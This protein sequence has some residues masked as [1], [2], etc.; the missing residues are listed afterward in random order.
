MASLESHAASLVASPGTFR[1]RLQTGRPEAAESLNAI[2]QALQ[3]LAND[4]NLDLVDL[5]KNHKRCLPKEAPEHE[6]MK[7]VLRDSNRKAQELREQLDEYAG[8]KLAGR[9][10]KTW[11]LRAGLSNSSVP[12][13][14]L[15]Q[16]FC[17][18][19]IEEEN[20]ISADYIGNVRN[21][22]CETLKHFN[23]LEGEDLGRDCSG[24][25]FITHVHHE[26]LLRV[27]PFAAGPGKRLR[28]ARYPKVLEHVLWVCTEKQSLR[29]FCELQALASQ[30]G[31][32]TAT[33]MIHVLEDVLEFMC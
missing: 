2:G 5:Q 19:S 14:T 17:D 30:D 10:R 12:A 4:F 25:V 28:G 26:A 3:S 13:E 29:C 7:R 20:K 21:A 33:C 32:A 9:L 1:D 31:P 27:W 23:R 6:K 15:N 24:S 16:L 22:L 8:S 11:L 18:F